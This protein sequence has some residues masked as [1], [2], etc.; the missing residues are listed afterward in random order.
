VQQ[1]L[2]F[3]DGVTCARNIGGGI[4]VIPPINTE[5]GYDNASPINTNEAHPANLDFTAP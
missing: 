3:L 2:H 1:D 4:I 5:G